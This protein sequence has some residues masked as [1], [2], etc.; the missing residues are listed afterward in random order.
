M[1]IKT[2]RFYCQHCHYNRYTDGTDID[3]LVEVPLSSIQG[4]I[5]YLDPVDK[6][7]IVPEFKK[8][9]KKFKC[10]NCGRMIAPKKIQE[11]HD[12]QTHWTDGSKTSSEG[13]EI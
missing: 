4:K 6:K 8:R 13:Q 12:E 7:A 5:P 3:D 10:P 2:Y 1:S 9:P 11:T